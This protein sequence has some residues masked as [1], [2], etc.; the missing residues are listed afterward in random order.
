VRLR[1][2]RHELR[3]GPVRVLELVDQDVAEPAGYG[4]A[5]RRRVAH[6]TQR[7][8]HLIPEIDEPVG[9]QQVLIP[10]ERPREL[11][12]PTSV[13]R[14]R[15]SRLGP[16]ASGLS[17]RRQCESFRGDTFRIARIGRRGDVLVLAA[18][19]QGRE[20]AQEPRRVAEWPVLLQIEL[21]Q[22]LAQED[23]DLC[24]RQDADIR[25]QPE[26]ERV[27][28]DEPVTE[29]VERGDGGIR[30]AIRDELVHPDRHLVRRL[31]RERQCQDLR[32]LRPT[33]SDQ[34]RDPTSD[35]LCLA[36]SGPRDHEHRPIAMRHRAELVRVQAAEQRLHAA[37]AFR[38]AGDGRIHDR[39][40]LAPGRDLLERHRPA[41]ASADDR[42]GHGG[43]DP[44]WSRVSDGG[45]VR[46]IAD[47]CD[48]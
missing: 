10:T 7:E 12:L 20:G 43:G 4:R 5:R 36:G 45:H 46:T 37:L 38:H 2:Q 22:V 25:R 9:G 48:T 3:L 18:A 14:E 17:G 42:S 33:R 44:G 27:L 40:E 11:D 13:F 1:E 19:E 29:G 24:S 6:E 35:D 28:A 23:H 34:P 21:V 41:P 8:R 32:R 15:S 39:D 16:G 26:L 30:V 31:V 47:R